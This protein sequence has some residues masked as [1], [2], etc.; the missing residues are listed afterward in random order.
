MKV[1]LLNDFATVVGGAERF[2]EN[3]LHEARS[4]NIDFHRINVAELERDVT[5]SKTTNFIRD[6]YNR[7]RVIP[8]MVRLISERINAIK[9]DLIH[10]NNNNLFTNSVMRSLQKSG[11]PVVCFIHNFYAL[12]RLR[13]VIFL[14]AKEKF[15]F[16]THSPDI[17]QKLVPLGQHTYIVKVPFNHTKWTCSSLDVFSGGSV[18]L[19]YVGRIEKATG[20]FKLIRAVERIKQRIPSIS[21]AILG[22][23]SKLTALEKMV[24]K[25]LNGQYFNQRFST[26]QSVSILLSSFQTSRISFRWGDARL[27]WSRSAVLRNSSCGLCQ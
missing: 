3:L 15:I 9:P 20:I 18:D 4:S 19:L 16:M 2:L 10:L 21:L 27:C 11:I 5:F 17:Y 25:K 12:R 6:R 13:S 23:G 24:K 1:L 7:I 22:E 26:R 14:P 8:Q